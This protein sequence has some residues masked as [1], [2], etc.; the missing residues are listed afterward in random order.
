MC[1]GGTE[2][3]DV[4]SSLY[5]SSTNASGTQSSALSPIPEAAWNERGSGSGLWASGGGAST[6][7]AKPF[8]QTGPGVSADRKRDVPDV[9]LGAAGHDGYLKSTQKGGLAST[10]SVGPRLLCQPWPA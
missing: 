4:N 2:F 7:Y 1:V 3:K 8:W 5:W 6:I 9:S 10:S